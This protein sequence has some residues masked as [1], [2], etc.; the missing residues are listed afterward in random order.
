MVSVPRVGLS[1]GWVNLK[2]EIGIC[3]FSDKHA[4][5]NSK[6]KDLLVRNQDNVSERW[7]DMS[8]H[9]Y[10]DPIKRVGLVQSGHHSHYLFI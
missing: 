10:K 6:N 9:D 7:S 3:C 2:T 1:S 4:A 8:T 5:L